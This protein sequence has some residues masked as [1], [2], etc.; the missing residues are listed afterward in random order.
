[1]LRL[2]LYFLNLIECV[3][4]TTEPQKNDFTFQH[5]SDKTINTSGFN[6][7]CS[8]AGPHGG[9]V[10]SRGNNKTDSDSVFPTQSHLKRQIREELSLKLKKPSCSITK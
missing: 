1:M 6:S 9:S 10:V 5:H 3:K 2:V 4:T 8:Q 7:R